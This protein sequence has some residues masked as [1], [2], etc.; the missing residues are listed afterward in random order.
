MISL[1]LS[2]SLSL[3]YDPKVISSP[4]YLEKMKAL[5]RSSNENR[6]FLD[7]FP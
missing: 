6:N 2:L 4:R 7:A 1:S 5:R 3:S